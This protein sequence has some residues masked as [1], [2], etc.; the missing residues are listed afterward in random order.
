ME[1]SNQ[2]L[3]DSTD[4]LKACVGLNPLPPYIL[5]SYI[6]YLIFL[7]H[8]SFLYLQVSVGEEKVNFAFAAHE[9]FQQTLAVMH[10]KSS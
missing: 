9:K 10:Q 5:L 8:S 7:C 2:V 1:S 6:T 4:D 3:Y